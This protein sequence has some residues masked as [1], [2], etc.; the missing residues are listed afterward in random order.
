MQTSDPMNRY[1]IWIIGCQM[2]D[3]DSRCAAE[4]LQRPGYF[5]IPRAEEAVGLAV[6]VMK[7]L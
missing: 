4:E 1:H 6:M 3:A 7:S 2:N 5:P